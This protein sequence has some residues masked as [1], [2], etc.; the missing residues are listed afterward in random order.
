MH[1][2]LQRCK[3][4]VQMLSYLVINTNE[5]RVCGHSRKSYFNIVDHCISDCLCVYEERSVFGIHFRFNNELF[6]YL[7]VLSK[8]MLFLVHS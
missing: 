8:D 3:S 1:G 4:V 6:E 5:P 7:G 2:F